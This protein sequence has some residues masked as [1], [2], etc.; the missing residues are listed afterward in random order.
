MKLQNRATSWVLGLLSITCIASAGAQQAST[1]S[2]PKVGAYEQPADTPREFVR[3]K[4]MELGLAIEPV[5]VDLGEWAGLKS[6]PQGPALI[7]GQSR[8]SAQTQSTE[9]VSSLLRWQSSANGGTVAAISVRSGGAEAMRLGVV[10]EQLPGSAIFRLYTD[11]QP[12][13]V[14]EIAGQRVM[15][16]LQANLD[17]GDVG[18]AGRTWWTPTSSGEQITLEIALPPGIASDT[19]Q[20]ALPR[21][22]HVYENLSL[23]IQG[24]DDSLVDARALPA[25]NPLSCHL[26]S[27]CYKQYESQSRGV[28]RMAYVM[29]PD[30]KGVQY[31]GFCTG[32]LLNDAKSSGT[33]YFLT[34]AHCISSQAV[35]STLE[36]DW[37]FTASSCSS[38]K[39]SASTVNLKN[40]AQLLYSSASP[41]VTLLKLND[42]PPAGAVYLGW[43]SNAVPIS[44]NVVGIHNPDGGLQKISMG[45]VPARLDCGPATGNFRCAPNSSGSYYGVQWVQGLTQPGS[46]GSPLFYQGLVTGVLSGGS[47]AG[48]YANSISVYPSLNSVFPAL[49]KWLY[50]TSVTPAPPGSLRMPVYR[51]YNTQSGTHFFTASAAERDGVIASYR[52][53]Q[54]EGI[55]FYASVQ[56]PSAPNGVFRFFNTNS[57]SHFYTINQGERDSIVA[58]YPALKPEG[59]VWYARQS[60]GD[61]ST[62]MYRFFNKVTGAHFYTVTAAERDNVIAAMPNMSYEGIAYYVWGSP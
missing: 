11:H 24:L 48:C 2:P 21:L 12:N 15:Q 5:R 33:P 53:L 46:S 40:G 41:D 37:F 10:V 34:A 35:A 20:I 4:S 45:E 22:L 61:A 9:A 62:P 6:S 14:Y 28:A 16:I 57:G 27:T 8:E 43:D 54:Y 32:S 55:G 36:T 29:P 23:P 60:A 31:Y 51:F 25:G 1:H 39:L 59:T 7:V 3:T 44:A 17:A 58:N 13:A 56:S 42:A 26:D 30:A 50:D 38:N 18:E 19:V 49:K 52:F 47:S